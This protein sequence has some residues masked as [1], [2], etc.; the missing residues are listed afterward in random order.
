MVESRSSA[1]MGGPWDAMKA[2]KEGVFC[3]FC[4][5][6]MSDLSPLPWLNLP[7]SA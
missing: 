3:C 4:F 2:V 5:V 7:I 1:H 6:G